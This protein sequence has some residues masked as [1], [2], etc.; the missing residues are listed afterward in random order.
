MVLLLF[1]V[2]FVIC[3]VKYVHHSSVC[4]LLIFCYI[5]QQCK[6]LLKSWG[7][8]EYFDSLC[9]DG[10]D[11][12]EYWYLIKFDHLKKCEFKRVHA[13]MFL[14][15]VKELHD[16]NKKDDD[17]KDDDKKDDDKKNQEIKELT[18]KQV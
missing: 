6:S 14:T 10:W 3:V 9:K 11:D 4:N 13:S 17:K 12:T 18:P 8:E 5:I 7:L 1:L 2:Y 16:D 15:K